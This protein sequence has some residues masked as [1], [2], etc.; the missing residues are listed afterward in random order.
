MEE[1]TISLPVTGPKKNML[2]SPL[3]RALS[4]INSDLGHKA[5]E[6]SCPPLFEANTP[7][8]HT[9][10]DTNNLRDITTTP[11]DKFNEFSSHLKVNSIAYLV[12]DAFVPV[13]SDFELIPTKIGKQENLIKEYIDFLNVASR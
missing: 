6:G 11:L 9:K 13:T 2:Q 4:P 12:R 8:V 3:R 7:T 5:L 1:M 10:N